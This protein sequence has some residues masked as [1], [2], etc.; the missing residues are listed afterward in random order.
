[1]DEKSIVK[2]NL[3]LYNIPSLMDRPQ[4]QLDFNTLLPDWSPT[5]SESGDEIGGVG[6]ISRPHSTL[7]FIT[8]LGSYFY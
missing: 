5:A 3:R 2:L 4:F 8:Q 6:S 1:M 7:G